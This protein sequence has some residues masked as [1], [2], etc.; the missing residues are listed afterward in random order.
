LGI[1]Y[2]DKVIVTP[3]T[4]VASGGWIRLAGARPVFADI[5]RDSQNL[6]AGTIAKVLTPKTRAIMAVHLA[7]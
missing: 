2:G 3:R 4:F 6:T 1:G 5:D 7:G